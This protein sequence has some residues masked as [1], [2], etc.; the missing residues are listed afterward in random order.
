MQPERRV[1]PSLSHSHSLTRAPLSRCRL[2]THRIG[3]AQD[4]RHTHLPARAADFGTSL[5]AKME[6]HREIRTMS[7]RQIKDH[8]RKCDAH[9]KLTLTSTVCSNPGNTDCF[10]PGITEVV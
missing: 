2:G 6:K 1:P 10:L 4:K 3:T 7:V 9:L 8:R 5:A